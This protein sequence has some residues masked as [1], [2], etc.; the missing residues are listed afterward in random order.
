M[1]GRK[2][3]PPPVPEI[4]PVCAEDVPRGALACPEC[5]ADHNSGWREETESYN[6]SGLPEAEFDYEEFVRQEFRSGPK[7]NAIKLGWWITAI[8]VVVIFLAGWF[9]A[10]YR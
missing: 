3:V 10:A 5:G 9:Y 6:G 7:P 2:L 8:L 4:C 1:A